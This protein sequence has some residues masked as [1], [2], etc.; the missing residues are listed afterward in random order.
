MIEKEIAEIRRRFRP[1]KCNITNVH[2]C[3]VNEKG[4]IVAELCQSLGL[5]PQEESEKMLALLRR[6]LS[7]TVNKNLIDI[8]F[9]TK[10]VVDSDEHRLLMSL[11][12]SGLQEQESRATL[13]QKII[14]TQPLEGNYLILLAYDKYDVLYRAADGQRQDDASADLFTYFVCAICPVTETKPALGYS[15]YENELR[16]CKLDW[17]V[18]PP[19]LGFLFPAFDDRSANIYNALYYC[20]DTANNHPAFVAAMFGAQA[21]MPPAMQK[22]T[23][24]TLLSDTLAE[25]CRF[26]VVQAVHGQLSGMIV[27]HKANKETA[28]L[29]VTKGT[30]KGMLQS[31]GVATERLALFEKKYDD[32][33][34]ADTDLSPRNLV[35][36][37][38]FALR[39]PDVTIN[40]NP[41]RS[42][43][44]ETR[45]IDGR[46]YILIRVEE[47][48]EVNGVAVHISED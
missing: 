3:Y 40:V 14:A 13:Y 35:D 34:G 16:S 38:K 47:G 45:I 6:T 28:P 42:E 19:E 18:A 32:E 33:F 31:C 22:E 27:E 23:F 24:E 25:D 17:P 5:M 44:V 15:L 7:G 48:V 4:E 41:E 46:P 37:K 26:E 10:Q 20:R 9:E 1:E 11:R 2:G 12:S 39:T 30:V 29:A 8:G 43:L 36:N 21:P